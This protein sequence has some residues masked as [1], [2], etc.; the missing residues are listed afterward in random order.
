MILDGNGKVAWCN[1]VARIAALPLCCKQQ[2]DVVLKA[3]VASIYFNCFRCFIGI[4]QVFHMDVAKVN[5]DVAY[6]AM[7]IYACCKRL[8]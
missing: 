1:L 5:R 3:N 7:A 4:S 8:F 6:V 2:G